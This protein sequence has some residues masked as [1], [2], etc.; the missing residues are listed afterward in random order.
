MGPGL[1][2]CTPGGILGLTQVSP[3]LAGATGVAEMVGRA[4]WGWWLMS[5]S[6]P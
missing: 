5:A 1:P 6:P 4:C 3:G 2:F